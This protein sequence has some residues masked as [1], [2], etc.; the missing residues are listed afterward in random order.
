[1]RMRILTARLFSASFILTIAIGSFAQQ[2]QVADPDFDTSVAKPA[3]TKKHPKVL[4]DE[5]HYNFHTSTGRYKAFADLIT[6]D[7]YEV[8]PNKQK[9]SKELLAGFDILVISNA[10]GA[11]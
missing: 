11:L 8:T 7:G 10:L 3:Y 9:F 5:A 1:M 2:Q 4:F 6:H